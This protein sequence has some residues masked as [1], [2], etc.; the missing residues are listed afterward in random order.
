MTHAARVRPGWAYAI[1]PVPGGALTNQ[2]GADPVG[3][4]RGYIAR[5]GGCN[6]C[7][8]VA[9]DVSDA[10]RRCL[11]AQKR[12]TSVPRQSRTG[13]GCPGSYAGGF[14]RRRI[15]QVKYPTPAAR[16]IVDYSPARSESH[17]ASTSIGLASP[18]VG[19]PGRGSSAPCFG[20]VQL[21][22]SPGAGPNSL[23]L[24]TLVFTNS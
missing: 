7:G 13:C 14:S 21:G 15:L 12:W 11:V 17:C 24:K 23:P 18:S 6:L 9:A 19:L 8:S 22:F 4:I 3:G 1:P 16:G 2:P 10:S 5:G 20:T